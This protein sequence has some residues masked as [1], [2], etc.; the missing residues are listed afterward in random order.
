MAC[1]IPIPTR[2]V[3]VRRCATPPRGHAVQRPRPWV[4]VEHWSATATPSTL[5]GR[6]DIRFRANERGLFFGCQLDH[7]PFFAGIAQRGEDLSAQSKIGMTHVGFF[8]CLRQAQG[9]PAKVLAGHLQH[10][11]A[12]TKTRWTRR[13]EQRISAGYGSSCL[14][15]MVIVQ[16]Q[17][18]MIGLAYKTT[19]KRQ[20][21]LS[22]RVAAMKQNHDLDGSAHRADFRQI[23]PELFYRAFPV[24]PFAMTC[25]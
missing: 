13:I 14:R 24:D 2:A 5:H 6:K 3:L 22:L 9:D 11:S 17:C 18:G 23:I 1:L 10:L 7:R 19:L 21:G 4:R 25:R 20:C 16:L 15:A 12:S 8:G